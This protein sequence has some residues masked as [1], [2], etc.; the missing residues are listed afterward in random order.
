M[1]RYELEQDKQNLNKPSTKQLFEN[2]TT[3]KSAM[4]HVKS[5]TAKWDRCSFL[6]QLLQQK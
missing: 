1:T 4:Q 3:G 5:G 6:L 2:M